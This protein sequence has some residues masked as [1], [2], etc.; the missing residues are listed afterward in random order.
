MGMGIINCKEAL[1]YNLRGFFK[2]IHSV[3]DMGD[4]DLSVPYDILKPLVTQAGLK[5]DSRCNETKNFPSRP[6][7]PLSAFWDLLGIE[8]THRMDI[9]ASVGDTIVTCSAAVTRWP[10]A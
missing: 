5:L 6:R 2:D 8:T 3:M 9:V 10:V 1:N 4:M 7:V